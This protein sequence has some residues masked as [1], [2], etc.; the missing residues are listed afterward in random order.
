MLKREQD[1]NCILFWWHTFYTKAG[2]QRNSVYKQFLWHIFT[3]LQN[4]FL[5]CHKIPDRLSY[6]VE[7][8]RLQFYAG[9]FILYVHCFVFCGQNNFE[10]IQWRNAYKCIFMMSR[11]S[12]S[13]QHKTFHLLRSLIIDIYPLSD[14]F[15]S[16]RVKVDCC[17]N[18]YIFYKYYD[19]YKICTLTRS[20]RWFQFLFQ[21]RKIWR[22]QKCGSPSALKIFENMVSRFG[23]QTQPD[24]IQDTHPV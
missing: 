4:K 2:R 24:Q 16:I 9:T 15:I 8:E 20:I 11:P 14:T 3:C 7:Q 12:I 23:Q 5:L 1:N 10:F 21:I 17:T 6:V 13:I 22:E 18:I 19:Q